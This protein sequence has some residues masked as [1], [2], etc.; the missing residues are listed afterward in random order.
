MIFTFV[1]HTIW[2]NTK[3][4]HCLFQPKNYHHS[5]DII[6]HNEVHPSHYK[7][8]ELISSKDSQVQAQVYLLSLTCKHIQY[9]SSLPLFANDSKL[10]RPIDSVSSPAL[11]QSDLDGL[12]S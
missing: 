6:C 12:H 7:F 4:P 2:P 10:Y 3:N 1:V 8:N 5:Y 11:L 9:G